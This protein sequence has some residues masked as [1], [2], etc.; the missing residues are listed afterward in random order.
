MGPRGDAIAQLDWCT[1]EIL[2]TLD[3]LKLADNTLVVF[4][5]DNGPVVDDGYRDAAVKKLGDHRPAGP[6]RGGKYSA[7]EGGTRVPLVVRWPKR[8]KP[9][10][11]DA[12]VCQVDF[13]ASL[14]AL[15][16]QTL[17]ADDAP[18]SLNVLPALLGKDP[19]GR[20]HLVEHAA[21]L[22]LRRGPWKLIQ[23]GRGP[24]VLANTDIESG[25][26]PEP[27]LYHLAD[28]LG[29]TR[30]LAAEHPEKLRELEELLEAIRRDGR[31]PKAPR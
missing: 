16:G 8:I 10:V 28:D 4:T 23:A 6:L 5:S 7:F 2:K 31:T 27:Q 22:S 24:K 29:E 18:D 20:D 25:Q 1:G 9:A 14:A 13:L 19:T 21:V 3:R 12:L 15:T 30:N 11:S 26:S 17:A